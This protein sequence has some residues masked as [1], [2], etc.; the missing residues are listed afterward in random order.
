MPNRAPLS[1]QYNM[2]VP[3]AGVGIP[4][5]WRGSSMQSPVVTP[6]LPGASFSAQGTGIFDLVTPGGFPRGPR[7]SGRQGTIDVFVRTPSIT[8]ASGVLALSA[9]VVDGDTVTVGTKTYTFQDT[10][11]NVDGNVHVGLTA[12]ASIANLVD[13]INLGA[14]AGTDYATAMTLHPTVSAGIGSSTTLAATAKVGGASGNLIATTAVSG[15][16][17]WGDA[18]LTGGGPAARTICYLTDNPTSP[19]RAIVLGMDELNR[20]TAEITANQE[21]DKATGTL[22]LTGNFQDAAAT[23]TLTLTGNA[24]NPAATGTLTL[25]GNLADGNTVTIGTKTYTFQ[26][27]LTNIDGN[28]LIGAFAWDSIDNLISAINLAAGAGTTY[29]AA[30]TLHPTVTAVAGA[31]DTLEATAKVL[32]VSGNSIV[33]TAVSGAASWGAASL[34]GGVTETATIGGK[35]YTFDTVLLN[36]DGH[37]LIAATASGTLNNLIAAINL[38]VGAGS[39]YAAA[40]TLHPTVT[41]TDGAGDTMVVTA[42]TRGPSGNAITTTEAIGTGSWGGATLAGGFFDTVTIGTKVYTFQTNMLNLDGRV[43]IAATTSDSI[44]NLIAAINRGPGEGTRYALAMTAHPDVTAVVG[45]GTSVVT[46]AKY[47]GPAGNTIATTETS[48]NASWGAATLTGG[49]GS[50]IST[51][52]ELVP[53]TTR[54]E[55]GSLM[56]RLAW[57][58]VNPIIDGRYVTLLVNQQAVPAG[59]W[60]TDP[61]EGWDAFMPTSLVMGSG[62]GGDAA[63]DGTILSWQGSE[64]VTL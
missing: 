17:T 10:L 49:S 9:N 46:T 33:T 20:P 21:A 5:T 45:A 40:T 6:Q 37:V 61:T 3:T 16:A 48:T 14:G 63:F 52:A 18:T 25:L 36:I 32:G 50:P 39:L 29:A 7:L 27:V 38:G 1:I 35:V 54:I 47:G 34:T 12:A 8:S 43:Q 11:T 57:D 31:G 64:F 28:V 59:D 30:T 22:T 41:A 58:S 53:S 24:V 26:T 19:T 2:G 55:G 56:I 42:K 15:T 62:F 51:L 23:G 4:P 44:A 60:T 13:A